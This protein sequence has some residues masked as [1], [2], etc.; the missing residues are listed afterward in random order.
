MCKDKKENSPLPWYHG[1]GDPEVIL[2]SS[3]HHALLTMNKSLPNWETNR[4]LIL[5]VLNALPDLYRFNMQIP[6][7]LIGI[8]KHYGIDPGDKDSESK[9]V[10]LN[11]KLPEKK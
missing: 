4:D 7:E 8:A 1:E 3:K 6:D 2:D 9:T 10:T 5:T 11:V